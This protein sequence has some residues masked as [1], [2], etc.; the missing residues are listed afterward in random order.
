MGS[1]KL[2]PIFI[3]IEKKKL[4]LEPALGRTP[5]TD[6]PTDSFLKISEKPKNYPK[7]ILD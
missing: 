5:Q 1:V 6:E 4:W 2:Q 3:E 7:L